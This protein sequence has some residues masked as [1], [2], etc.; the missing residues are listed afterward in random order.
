MADSEQKPGLTQRLK[1]SLQARKERAAEKARVKGELQRD[2][3]TLDKR[4]TGSKGGS[5]GGV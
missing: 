1:G 5:S 2:R 3:A 4:A